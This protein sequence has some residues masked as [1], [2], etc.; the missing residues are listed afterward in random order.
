MRDVKWKVIDSGFAT[1]KANMDFDLKLLEELKEASSPILHVYDW[2]A[3]SATYG[4]FLNPSAYLSQEAFNCLDLSKRPTGGGVT[5]HVSDWAFSIL[6]PA[7]HKA[8]SINTLD[9]YAFVNQLVIKVL[10]RFLGNSKE[11]SLLSDEPKAIDTPSVNFCM[12]KPTIFDVMMEGK[13]VGGGAQRRKHFGFL[14]QGTIS[15]VL[16]DKDFFEKVLLPGTSVYNSILKK[17]CT[18]LPL[19]ASARDLSEARNTLKEIFISE[20]SI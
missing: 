14:H 3:S 6:I 1:A 2:A 5:F 7:S 16:P 19:T 15:L 13:K 18:L 4:Y 20:V 10:K 12:A 17:T 11:L 8:Y 9:N